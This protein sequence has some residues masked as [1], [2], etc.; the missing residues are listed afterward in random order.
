M[1][2]QTHT[3]DAKPLIGVRVCPQ[4]ALS[5]GRGALPKFAD[6]AGPASCTTYAVEQSVV[7]SRARRRR[8]S[9]N[10]LD[11]R[12]A[13]AR[14][15]NKRHDKQ[16]DKANKPSQLSQFCCPAPPE[17][18]RGTSY[19]VRPSRHALLSLPATAGVLILHNTTPQSCPDTR[20]DDTRATTVQPA[21]Q[22]SAVLAFGAPPS[23]GRYGDHHDFGMGSASIRA[24]RKF[25]MALARCSPK[26]NYVS[27]RFTFIRAGSYSQSLT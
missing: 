13:P 14:L 4:V 3:S 1:I 7:L 27:H 10:T 9:G 19:C 20:A 24:A 17:V 16:V 26:S 25:F 8:S 21:I 2:I 11:V 5:A 15:G 12:D 23:G 22:G 18:P 6:S